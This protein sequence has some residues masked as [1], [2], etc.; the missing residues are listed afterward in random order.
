MIEVQKEVS[1]YI[2]ITNWMFTDEQ[3]EIIGTFEVQ[4]VK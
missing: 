1:D 3:K 2:D 4:E